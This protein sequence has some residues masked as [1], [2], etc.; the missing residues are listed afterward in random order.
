[1]P[2]FHKGIFHLFSGRT[3]DWEIDCGTLTR[4]DWSC[5]A[6][7][8]LERCPNFSHVDCAS[9]SG[10]ILKDLLTPHVTTGDI[11]LINDVLDIDRM[12]AKRLWYRTRKEYYNKDILGYVVF[13]RMPCPNWIRSLWQLDVRTNEWE[14]PVGSFNL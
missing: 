1:M 5:I 10:L 11:L 13:A 2:L 4:E 6:D 14:A 7:L 3:A 9:T 12:Q 8:I